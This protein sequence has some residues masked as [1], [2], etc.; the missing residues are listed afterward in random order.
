MIP[1]SRSDADSE[2]L[3]IGDRQTGKTSIA[4]DT[5]L[6]QKG[7][8]VI[9]IYVAIG[10]KA[11][12]IAK[13]VN[14]LKTHDAM[15]YTIVMA[16]TASDPAPLQYIAPYA[17]MAMAEFFMRQ[18]RDVLIVYDDLSSMQ[19]LTVHCLCCWSVLRDVRHIRVMCFICTPDCWS[20]PVA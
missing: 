18:G 12:T 8:G 16:S 7:K 6:N 19:L 17:G 3:I 13:L 2:K 15:D 5:M 10:Q 14:T 4:V 20:G 1:C 9:C 11:S